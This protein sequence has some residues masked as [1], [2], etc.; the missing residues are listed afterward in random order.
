MLINT[1]RVTHLMKRDGLDSLLATTAEN[2]YY[3]SGVQSL[4]QA[5]FP[6]D[7][8]VYV[9]VSCDTLKEPIA[10][11]P[12]VDADTALEGFENTKVMNYGDF[13]RYLGENISLTPFE[14]QLKQIVIDTQPK[15]DAYTALLEVIQECGLEKKVLG[16]DERGIDP[17]YINRLENDLPYITLKPVSLIFKEIR[18][19]KTAEEISRIGMAALITE[20]AI[21]KSL[22]IVREGISEIDLALEFE[23]SLL[24]A[25]AR[26]NFTCLHFGRNI[27]FLETHPNST[28]LK[29]HDLIWFDVGCYYK[30]YASDTSRVFAF[31]DPGEHAIN[32]YQALYK[33]WHTGIQSIRSG[34]HTQKVFQDCMT[35]VR[36]NGIPGYNRSHV[37][38]GIGL[39]TYDPPNLSL[40]DAWQLEK[41]MVINLELPYYEIGF[42]GFNIED[43][44]VVT[45]GNPKMLTS[46][47]RDLVVL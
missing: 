16:Y 10:I 17:S 29:N 19:V 21:M 37:G 20:N 34:A 14:T 32:L 44:L 13:Y 38:H 9:L 7:S 2:V 5:M 4:V 1:E 41:G 12:T 11:I 30:G 24:D 25:G 6:R 39:E 45:D 18:M 36:E 23:K 46:L 42:G 47:D 28:C 26:L 22:R 3:L 8:Q 40:N 31:G 33:G 27:A 35:S 15:K 43:T